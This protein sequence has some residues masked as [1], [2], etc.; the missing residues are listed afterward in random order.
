[1]NNIGA[2]PLVLAP[3]AQGNAPA[4]VGPS[5]SDPTGVALSI[6]SKDQNMSKFAAMA[7]PSTMPQPSTLYACTC[8]REAITPVAAG[9]P[10]GWELRDIRKFDG[11]TYQMPL[12]PD[13]VAFEA[14]LSP[15]EAQYLGERTHDN[16]S[17][18]DDET[19]PAV[20]PIFGLHEQDAVVALKPVKTKYRLWQATLTFHTDKGATESKVIV[21]ADDS[22][23]AV[24]MALATV[25]PMRRAELVSIHITPAPLSVPTSEVDR[26]MRPKPHIWP[27]MGMHR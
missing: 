14:S 17:A 16:S 26:M 22:A 2:H 12:C 11:G 13:C 21:G 20:W 15:A 4:P 6:L 9:L 7:Q 23:Q 18:V 27:T 1:M 19:P 24:Q 8:E 5:Q 10:A 3:P 25:D